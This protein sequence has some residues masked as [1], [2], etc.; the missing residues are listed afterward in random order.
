LLHARR[1]ESAERANLGHEHVPER[2]TLRRRATLLC[3]GRHAALHA[4]GVTGIQERDDALGVRDGI[5]R[6]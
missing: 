5:R 2:V 4:V 3:L 6:Q 1:S